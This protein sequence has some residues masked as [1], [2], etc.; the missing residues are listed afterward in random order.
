MIKKTIF[1]D[2]DGCIFLHNGTIQ[3]IS[4]LPVKVLDGVQKRFK[5]WKEAGHYIILVS[6][7][8]EYLRAKTGEDLESFGLYYDR[9]ILGLPNYP[10]VLINDTKPYCNLDV[11]AEAITVTRDKGLESVVI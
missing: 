2:I 7:R 4:E 1:C 6:A 5:E 10:R 3:E 8:P 11:T 9:L